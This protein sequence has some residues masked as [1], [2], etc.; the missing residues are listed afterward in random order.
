MQKNN[1]GK[2]KNKDGMP[3][4]L[5][6]SKKFNTSLLLD[7]SPKVS[8]DYSDAAE[9]LNNKIIAEGVKNIAVVASFGAGKSSAIE[10][11]L[12]THRKGKKAKD[13]FTRISLGSFNDTMYEDSEVERSI[14]QQLLYS[15]PKSKLPN[16][17]VE[18]TT[19]APKLWTAMLALLITLFI[20][21]T[22]LFGMQLGNV[23]LQE[24]DW[25]RWVLLSAAALSFFTLMWLLIYFRKLQRIKYKDFEIEIKK[26]DE[27]KG[28]QSLINRFVDEVLYFFE[29]TNINLV[30][31]EDLDRLKGDKSSRIFVKLRELN[32][33]INNSHQRKAKVTFLYAVKDDM[34]KQQEER[35]KFF[36]FILSIVPI[37]NPV[38]KSIKMQEEHKRI[39]DKAKDLKLDDEFIHAISTYIPDMRTLK[40]AF[41][42]YVIT[43]GR[44]FK[45]SA[46]G[47]LQN[48]NL[49]ALC[50][51]KNLYPYDYAKLE[52]GNGL[53]PIF[54]NKGNLISDEVKA[55]KEKIKQL[56]TIIERSEQE[57]LKSFD[58]LKILLKNQ[59]G[60]RSYIQVQ[61]Q[62]LVSFEEITTFQSFDFK[63][64]KHPSYNNYTYFAINLPTDFDSNFFVEREQFI[65]ARTAKGKEEISQQIEREKQNIAKYETMS[66]IDLIKLKG[67]DFHFKAA[68]EEKAAKAYL[69]KLKNAGLDNQE[70]NAIKP[71]DLDSKQ[72]GFLKFLLQNNYL[73]EKYMEYTSSYQSQMLSSIDEQFIRKVQQGEQ[74]YN[75]KIDNIDNVI[76]QLRA[77]SFQDPAI[78]N[79]TVLANIKLLKAQKLKNEKYNNM[80]I[81]LNTEKAKEAIIT[82]VQNNEEKITVEFLHEILPGNTK[83]CGE[84]LNGS[85]LAKERQAWVI[86]ALINCTT[87]YATHNIEGK[88]ANFLNNTEYEQLLASTDATK[89][90]KFLSQIKP[91]FTKLGEMENELTKY[92]V[93]NNLYEINIENLK[94]ILG[95]TAETSDFHKKNYAFI[96]KNAKVKEHVDDQMAEYIKLVFAS[97][98]LANKD[99][100]EEIVLGFINRE[101]IPVQ[102]KI[103]IVRKYN[104]MVGKIDKY[105]KELHSAMLENNRVKPTWENILFARLSNEGLN[106]II[107]GFILRHADEIEGTFEYADTKSEDADDE[108]VKGLCE[109]LFIELAN[110]NY[111]ADEREQ[112]KKVIDKIGFEFDLDAD[113][114]QDDNLAV[115]I[116][117]GNIAYSNEDLQFLL[118]KPKALRQYAIT[119]LMEIN[120]EFDDF[121]EGVNAQALKTLILY[122]DVNKG[123]RQKLIT[124]YGNKVTV[125]GHEQDFYKCIKEDRFQIPTAM[126]VKFKTSTL[127]KEEKQDLATWTNDTGDNMA[128]VS[129]YMK[130]IIPELANIKKE[131][132]LSS[133]GSGFERLLQAFT[134]SNNLKLTKGRGK[135]KDE[136]IVKVG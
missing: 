39:V 60:G 22:V 136:V 129:D 102:Q 65:I 12:Q 119:Y 13:T 58:E 9:I 56:Q 90:K 131:V 125:S 112:Y 105:T 16:S 61:G 2:S 101:G 36:E 67:I 74:A 118:D 25:L 108:T 75:H 40:N 115:L 111:N 88:I 55:S 57:H 20:G 10:T 134:D 11:Y 71:F 42:D 95:V 89:S 94:K 117:K 85:M 99:E 69:D 41:N 78:L 19:A 50:L 45:E 52:Q 104:F 122:K 84:L 96:S 14:L 113:Y 83:I 5:I 128:L 30:I 110:A 106:D 54:M 73:D 37:M 31:F 68:A 8:E 72:L 97:D 15:Q 114:T 34:I 109:S 32:T 82:F 93:E 126:L 80:K 92:V 1:I 127:T 100:S 38:T 86:M 87:D 63:R 51:Y 98:D 3:E 33:I 59:I 49:F 81:L 79:N 48:E 124:E 35:A 44:I 4:E 64:I 26:G 130:T 135:N 7:N 107:K 18:R 46:E 29:S 123:L 43:R 103:A 116:E 132:R 24:V 121:F 70:E 6:L 77:K 66:M 133:V 23:F 91:R 21:S 62:Q 76:A 47:R 28:E 27:K 17:R 53:I 120:E